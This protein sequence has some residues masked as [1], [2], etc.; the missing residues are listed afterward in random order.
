MLPAG[1][2]MKEHR[3]IEK[4][5]EILK[6][7]VVRIQETGRFNPSFIEKTVDFFRI[8]ADRTHHGKEEDI[9][10]KAL[11]QKKMSAP[12]ATIM[13]ELIREHVFARDKVHSLE[14]AAQRFANDKTALKDVAENIRTLTSF[15]PAHIQKEDK[16]FFLPAMDYLTDKEKNEMLGDFEQ[17]DRK[18]IHEKYAQAIENFPEAAS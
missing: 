7:G 16:K 18:M 3:L 10:F 11:A 4:M 5:I 1:P 12:L 6:S 15:Y 8:Y 13:E 17:F 2:L 14:E 9:L